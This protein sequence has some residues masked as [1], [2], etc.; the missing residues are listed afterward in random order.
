M[1]EFAGDN[2]LLTSVK[3]SDVQQI[4][5]WSRAYRESFFLLRS[6][7][8]LASEEII[9]ELNTANQFYLIVRELKTEKACGLVKISNLNSPSGL[10]HLSFTMRPAENNLK[11]MQEAL[12]IILDRA[13][14][15]HKAR[16]IYVDLFPEE[17]ESKELLTRLLF[18]KEGVL[19]EHFYTK[20][21]FL[22]I[23]LFALDKAEYY[24]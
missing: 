11:L 8:P 19:K 12:E 3:T 20:N 17:K 2:L 1:V 18:V 9:I 15:K 21:K 5:E 13:F 10:C 14:S 7:L 4:I 23:E 6:F 24:K 16:R 22:D